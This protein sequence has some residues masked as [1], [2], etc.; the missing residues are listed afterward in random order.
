MNWF[1][2]LTK[3]RISL[4]TSLSGVVGYLL[5]RGSFES[6]VAI[7][8]AGIYLLAS[9]SSAL[10]QI[11]E[12]YY[13]AMMYRT[14]FRPIPSG[15]IT[16]RTATVIAFGL[17]LGGTS[18]LFARFGLIPGVLGLLAILWY[19]GI[20]T[21]LKRKTAFAVFPGAVI[22]AIPPAIGWTAAGGELSSPTIIIIMVYFFIWQMPHFWLL[23]MV[24]GNQYEQ[25]GYPS[26]LRLFQQDQIG[27]IIFV[28]TASTVIIS[29]L[30]PLFGILTNIYLY[31]ALLPFAFWILGKMVPFLKQNSFRPERVK[32]V[33]MAINMYAFSLMVLIFLQIGLS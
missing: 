3:Y 11:Q 16:V 19:N 17:M 24:Y 33:F 15:R 32:L 14:R 20:Y 5:F 1:L 9:G 13:D 7:T 4:L 31:L 2:Q 18:L 21:P 22:G 12:R 26:F 27:R 6:G 8:L 10:N 28:W 29:L 25:A 30:M 23:L